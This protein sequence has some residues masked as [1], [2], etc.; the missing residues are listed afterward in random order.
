MN[1]S[2]AFS[3]AISFCF[4]VSSGTSSNSSV[5]VVGSA[6][7]KVNPSSSAIRRRR[8]LA[9]ARWAAIGRCGAAASQAAADEQAQTSSRTTARISDGSERRGAGPESCL[10]CFDKK[11]LR[12]C[13]PASRDLQ[14]TYT[15]SPD[16]IDDD[17]CEEEEEEEYD[18]HGQAYSGH[19]GAIW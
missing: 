4:S 16:D 18:M 13:T 17:A 12:S 15:G 10:S 8:K 11:E 6:S 9:E 19:L 2:A 5:V 14:Y 3:R 1:F 7:P